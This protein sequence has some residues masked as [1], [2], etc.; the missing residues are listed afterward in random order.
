MREEGGRGSCTTNQMTATEIHIE[1]TTC[2]EN[3]HR[4]I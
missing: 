4:R 1:A 3:H 2:R